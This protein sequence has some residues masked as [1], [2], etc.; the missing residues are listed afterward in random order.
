MAATKR[1]P[2][3]SGPRAQRIR[4]R[5]EELGIGIGEASERLGWD[6]RVLST[7]LAAMEAPGGR[8]IRSDTLAK[9]EIVLQ[10]PAHW[11]LT[12]EYP[13]GVRLRDCP[14]WDQ[15]AKEAEVRLKI[16]R[17]TIDLIGDGRLPKAL[18][19]IDA[20]LIRQ[21]SDKL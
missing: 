16:P 3:D 14:G 18:R 6:R 20:G 11:I 8:N 5:L 12:G 7:L 17:E 10:R 19:E 13:E 21:I 4:D 9:L 1:A 15:A 2:V